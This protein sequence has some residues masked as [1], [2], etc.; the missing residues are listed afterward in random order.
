MLISKSSNRQRQLDE[1]DMSPLISVVMPVYNAM[2]YLKKSIDSVLK[3]SYADFELILIDDGS[4]DG[5]AKICD[6]YSLKDFRVKAYHQ[7]NQGSSAARNK[8]FDLSKGK[9]IIH[10]DADDWLEEDMLQKM[11]T[12]GERENADIVACAMIKETRNDSIVLLY[13]Y[14]PEETGKKRYKVDLLFSA[15]WNKLIRRDLYDRTGVRSVNGIKMWDDVVV[16]TKLRWNSNKTVIINEPLYHYRW[17]GQPS[18]TQNHKNK[19]PQD[20]ISVAEN[21]ASYFLSLKKIDN[22]DEIQSLI[23]Y[24]KLISKMTILTPVV[25]SDKKWI[26][27]EG[28]MG[29]SL[30]KS[31]FP[32]AGLNLKAVRL[33]QTP[34]N[35][36]RIL[37]AQYLPATLVE[38]ILSLMFKI[39]K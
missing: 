8:G 14:G 29:I 7:Q 4:T 22:K 6:E 37:M 16:T 30:W 13:P 34:H 38:T 18:I 11:I 25:K 2:D 33:I 35:I 27:R 3:Q 10:V 1:K 21:L 9:W 26:E 36:I 20:Q 5:S 24:Y 32:E 28:M 23:D 15:F 39:Y 17:M 12:V 31:I 19:Y